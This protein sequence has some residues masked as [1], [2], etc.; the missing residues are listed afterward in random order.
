MH[1]RPNRR[2]AVHKGFGWGEDAYEIKQRE[3]REVYD[4]IIL[5]DSLDKLLQEQEKE[6][7]FS[8][9]LLAP[10]NRR[11][12]YCFRMVKARISKDAKRYPDILL[13]RSQRGLLF[14]G[15]WSIEVLEMY[16][17]LQWVAH[18]TGVLT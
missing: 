13:I 5:D 9:R 16:K 14:P 2:L 11:M 18:T 15:N 12:K 3:G 6:V 17:D 1:E 10:E 8:I 7:T 4:T